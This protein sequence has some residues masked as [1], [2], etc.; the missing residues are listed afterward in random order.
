MEKNFE[1]LIID[2][3]SYMCKAGVA[4]D[5]GPSVVIPSIIGFP[6]QTSSEF[7][8]F[9]GDEAKLRRGILVFHYPI[10]RGIV[11]NWDEMEKIWNYIFYNELRVAPEEH[12][13]LLTEAPLN[14][15]ANR[16]KTTIIMFETFNVPAMYLQIQ[17]VLSL[18]AA[19]HSTGVVL[20]TGDSVSTI[21]PI[22]EGYATTDAINRLDI[23]GRHLTE[24]LI[25]I[26]TERGY[27]FR[28]AAERE[29]VRDIKEKL[30]YVALDFEAEL[31]YV[32]KNM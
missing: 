2:N 26:L 6:K 23:A 4:G 1:S 8:H 22:C 32:K 12:P 14:P 24:H 15:K 13:V 10:E 29:I 3:G 27:S 9:I 25:K 30:C 17:A 20:D 31:K 28:S 7:E 21:V 18:Y 16:E 5:D 11:T 19:G